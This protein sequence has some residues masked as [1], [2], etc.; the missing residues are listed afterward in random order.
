MIDGRLLLTESPSQVET[1]RGKC[2]VMAYSPRHDLTI[3]E[4]ND[5]E[6]SS[7]L[8]AWCVLGRDAN[9]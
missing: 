5:S 9:P 4:M 3:A 2:F 1:A 6:I 7:I 8:D